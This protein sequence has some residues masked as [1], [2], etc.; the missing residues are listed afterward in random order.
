[1]GHGRVDIAAITSLGME[2]EVYSDFTDQLIFYYHGHRF[3]IGREPMAAP[4]QPWVYGVMC[5]SL[6]EVHHCDTALEVGLAV[7]EMQQRIDDGG[8]PSTR[9]TSAKPI[10][11][12]KRRHRNGNPQA[13]R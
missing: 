11:N 4:R 6:G 9:P 7:C 8:L 13:S 1:M 10:T 12:P 3:V 2:G 5:F